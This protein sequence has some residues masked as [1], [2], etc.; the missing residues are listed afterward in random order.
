MNR[1]KPFR[2]I[3]EQLD[4]LES[5]GMAIPNRD[6]AA[7]YLLSNNYYTVV[8]GYKQLFLDPDRCNE[9]EEVYKQGTSFSHLLLAHSFDRILRT[10]TVNYILM[11]ESRMKTALI[12]AFCEKHS[13]PDAYLDPANYVP[14]GEY[15]K[16]HRKGTYTSNLI[17]LLSVLQSLRDGKQR[18]EY[19]EHY[20]KRYG[21][22]P[23]WV[24]ANCL[25]FGNLSAFYDLQTRGIQNVAA[26]HIAKSTGGGRIT[27]EQLKRCFRT[28][29]PFRNICAHN[30]RLFCSRAGKRGDMRY[31]DMAASLKFMLDNN[32]Y[33]TFYKTAVQGTMRPLKDNRSLYD[34]I[35]TE[36]GLHPSESEG[37]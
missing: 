2:T 5:R 26:K 23:L 21:N 13:E 35:R 12:Y 1:E 4:I 15:E 9:T 7:K 33:Q 34:T 22:V 20:H 28:L 18:T 17:R 16:S 29:V 3:D 36:M 25:T 6:T 31:A 14:R 24:I 19:V 11:A 10:M 27:P 37:R 8:N 32:E 30:E